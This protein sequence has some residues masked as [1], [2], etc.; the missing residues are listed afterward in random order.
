MPTA[1]DMLVAAVN[2]AL[3]LLR[4]PPITSLDQDANRARVAKALYLGVL[5]DLLVEHSWNFAEHE[6]VPAAESTTPDASGWYRHRLPDECLQI[7][8]VGDLEADEWK[9]VA[10]TQ[11]NGDDVSQARILASRALTPRV[12]STWR[13]T[14]ARLWSPKFRSTF[15][16][17]LAEA[18]AGPVAKDSE[19]VD[20]AEAKAERRLL[21]AKRRDGQESARTVTRKDTSWIAARRGWRR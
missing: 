12:V 19:A 1:A 5:D 13:I 3:A 8:S 4:E 15:E 16:A 17:R 18:M 10:P 7:V 20:R 14:N 9:V 21:K 2:G 11:P 6:F